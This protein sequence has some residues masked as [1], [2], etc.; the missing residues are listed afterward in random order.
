MVRGPYVE[1]A[2]KVSEATNGEINFTVFSSGSLLQR[3]ASLQ[4][5]PAQANGMEV[6]EPDQALKDAL[7]EFVEVDEAVP[8][9]N[10]ES[11][12]VE[13]ASVIIESYKTIVDRWDELLADVDR[14]DVDALAELARSE[15]YAQLDPATYGVE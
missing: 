1:F 2:E 6:Y 11:R 14:T 5:V 15:I 8:I 3:A 12:G 7:A 10:A 4:G 13:N 9:E